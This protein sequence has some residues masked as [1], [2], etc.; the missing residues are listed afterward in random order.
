MPATPPEEAANP[1]RQWARLAMFILVGLVVGFIAW[2]LIRSDALRTSAHS[3][4]THE[5]D[6]AAQVLESWPGSVRA[7]AIGNLSPGR[8]DPTH[9]SE[10][11][12]GW[13]KA[14]RFRHPR[15]GTFYIHY[16]LPRNGICPETDPNV[17]ADG[18]V[19]FQKDSG[20]IR[21]TGSV[22]TNSLWYAD[23]FARADAATVAALDP[24]E[25]ERYIIALGL[26][27]GNDRLEPG[28]GTDKICFKADLPLAEI[29][30]LPGTAP[31]L[32]KLLVLDRTGD[33]LAQVGGAPLPMAS[34]DELSPLQ[35]LL[36]DVLDAAT[37][38]ASQG[39]AAPK[40]R[41]ANRAVVDLSAPVQVTIGGHNY[42]AYARS[43]NLPEEFPALRCK[44]MPVATPGPAKPAGDGNPAAALSA[45]V[46]SCLVLGL[47]PSTRVNS[48][49]L[50]LSPAGLTGFALFLGLLVALLPVLKLRLIGPADALR[51]AEVAAIALGLVTAVAI[52]TLSLFFA[53]AYI[54]DNQR[55]RARADQIA[56]AMAADFHHELLAATAQPLAYVVIPPTTDRFT[57]AEPAPPSILSCR[58]PNGNPA[59]SMLSRNAQAP[60]LFISQSGEGWWPVTESSALFGE[61]GAAWPGYVPVLNRCD[62]GGRANIAQ[63]PYFKAVMDGSPGDGDFAAGRDLRVPGLDV[64]RSYRVAAVR[65]QPDGIEKVIIAAPFRR[66]STDTTPGPQRGAFVETFVPRSF[67]APVLP[68]PFD[69][70]VVNADDPALTVLFASNPSRIEVDRFAEDVGAADAE[71]AIR[72]AR[73]EKNNRQCG[74]PV[75]HFSAHYDGIRQHFVAQGLP[76]TPWVLLVHYPADAIAG[77]IAEAAVFAAGA[78]TGLAV[79]TLLVVLLV[80]ARHGPSFWHWSWPRPGGGVA[81]ARASRQVMLIFAGAVLVCALL[82]IFAGWLSGLLRLIVALAAPA[83]AI[84]IVIRTLNRHRDDAARFLDPTDEAGFRR[85][86]VAL[87]LIIGVLPMAVL[88]GDSRASSH[89]AR[90][91]V[92]ISH[93]DSAADANV[94]TRKTLMRAFG[95]DD[96]RAVS[97]GGGARSH[98][99]I[100]L[101]GRFSADLH[102]D[103][104]TR[105]G[106][107]TRTLRTWSAVEAPETPPRCQKPKRPAPAS[108]R[109]DA[110]TIMCGTADLGTDMI[111]RSDDGTVDI[112]WLRWFLFLLLAGGI[113]A[114]VFGALGV[115][116]R[117]LFGHG[118]PLEAVNYP[119]I[120]RLPDKRLDLPAKVL[121]LNAPLALRLELLETC[122]TIDLSDPVAVAIDTAKPRLL[123]TGLALALRDKELRAKALTALETMARAVDAA[124]RA[125][126]L[127]GTPGSAPDQI[128][129]MTDLSPLDRILQAYESEKAQAGGTL[130][131]EGRRE[132]LRWS[133]LFEAFATIGFTPSTK[134]SAAAASNPEFNGFTADQRD[135]MA[136][137][138]NEIRDLP[139]VVIDSLINSPEEAVTAYWRKLTRGGDYPFDPALFTRFYDARVRQWA[140]R[141]CPTSRAAAIDYLRGTLIEHYQYAWIASSHAERVILDSLAR[142]RTVN[143]AS[144]L[145]LRSLVRRGLVRFAPVPRLINHSFA[146]FVLQ[147]E[148]PMQINS[149]RQEHPRS[150]WQRSSVPLMVLVPAA[151]IGLMAIALYSGESAI[152]LMP[153]LL[154]SAPALIG[155]LGAIRRNS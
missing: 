31:E 144:A 48:A 21:I 40:P 140:R 80:A 51:R 28:T 72:I 58:R 119:G 33:L 41:E 152:R 143:I 46:K 38:V 151:I 141:V 85:L 67:V 90:D 84:A 34:L 73:C 104:E 81:Y 42:F 29:V 1:P 107:L 121:V 149:W 39:K 142:G 99:S 118:V 59:I 61:F 129:V 131:E 97:G 153:L 109:G 110:E 148:K 150:L 115:T 127:A 120:T 26:I 105:A 147:A 71:A 88:W 74:A 66:S 77:S 69:F 87:L 55:A 138:V 10:I 54:T 132:Q 108:M 4:N 139:E 82:S 24:A 30:D 103:A 136:T 49:S 12:K 79:V 32:E 37:T 96:P 68:T 91:A 2:L 60:G 78:W 70:R 124:E 6:I 36:E 47:V 83:V 116:L 75:R 126:D 89:A 8:I 92:Q 101:Y 65:A 100:G 27:A 50:R 133:R 35:P 19:R 130:P 23:R 25:R 122:Q 63:R 112:A 3:R 52:A 43:L 154:G 22:A 57:V 111:A 45:K 13:R 56:A 135:G 94:Q 128:I 134:V 16:G 98:D 15:L 125:H 146:A 76:G 145:A 106:P 137:L 7:M 5:L 113:A 93:L 95:T 14:A 18:D 123:V 86:A 11:E 20:R 9:P 155:T 53:Q 102:R 117:C 17:T 62:R 44:T 114:I 64:G